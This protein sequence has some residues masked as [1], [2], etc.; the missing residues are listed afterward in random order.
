MTH[1]YFL[2][3]FKLTVHGLV[4]FIVCGWLSGCATSV[5][6]TLSPIEPDIGDIAL[7]GHIAE[8]GGDRQEVREKAEAHLRG[9]FSRIL[10]SG[11]K[12]QVRLMAE[13]LFELMQRASDPE[14]R[15]R[16]SGLLSLFSGG[17]AIWKCQSDPLHEVIGDLV[18]IPVGE[19]RIIVG[20][21]GAMVLYTLCLNNGETLT[22]L[23][24]ELRRRGLL[25]YQWRS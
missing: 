23:E 13:K 2:T 25:G 15:V 16:A 11:D 20:E 9:Y 6:P 10:A 12:R 4:I 8:L 7:A 18:S 14:V 1:S 17:E 5:D 24:I 22:P 21:P 3:T 19:D